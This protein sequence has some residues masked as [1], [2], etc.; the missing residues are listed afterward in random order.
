[1]PGKGKKKTAIMGDILCQ[2]CEDFIAYYMA[3]GYFWVTSSRLFLWRPSG[4]EFLFSGL[5]QKH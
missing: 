5:P 3:E 2:Y 4:G 1:M